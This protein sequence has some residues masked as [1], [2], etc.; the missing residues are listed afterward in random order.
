MRLY[1]FDGAPESADTAAGLVGVNEWH[2]YAIVWS[3]SGSADLYVDGT[4]RASVPIGSSWKGGNKLLFGA[5]GGSGLTNS[6][7]G[8]LDEPAVYSTAL[9]ATTIQQ[10]YGSGTG[11]GSLKPSLLLAPL[12][13]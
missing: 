5:A 3:D 9:S 1:I 11:S 8:R 13:R 7:Q 2:Y 6:W 10:H 12:I 4:K